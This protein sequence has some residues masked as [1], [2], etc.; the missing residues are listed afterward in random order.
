VVGEASGGL[1]GVKLAHQLEPDVVLLD[2]DMPL[3]NG[4]EALEQMLSINHELAVLML[5][6]SE[7]GADLAD[8]MRLGARG[9]LLKNINIDFLL[10]SIRRAVDG[11]SVLSPEMTSKLVARLRSNASVAA[12]S[13]LELLTPRE[14]ETLVWLAKGVSNKHIARGMGVAESTIKVHVQNILRKLELSSRVQA[15]VYAVEHHLHQ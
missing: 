11:D 12:P 9:Y 6:V 8:C 15:A 5:T 3:M 7:D 10:D 1:E 13:K 2:L 14:L 4:K